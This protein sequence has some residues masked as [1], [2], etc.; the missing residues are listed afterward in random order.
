MNGPL[1]TR[2]GKFKGKLVVK[3]EK[4]QE[5]LINEYCDTSWKAINDEFFTRRQKSEAIAEFIHDMS[6]HLEEAK[7][8]KEMQDM[9][10]MDARFIILYKRE[11]LLG[12]RPEIAVY[13][14]S[15]G[16]NS[17][18]AALKGQDRHMS[19][20]MV[21]PHP[22]RYHLLSICVLFVCLSV[23]VLESIFVVSHTLSATSSLSLSLSPLYPC[24]TSAHIPYQ[25]T[26]TLILAGSRRRWGRDNCETRSCQD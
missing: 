17:M 21:R 14:Q 2:G 19:L 5:R 22:T 18:T 7:N 8:Q 23:C 12:T 20:G 16:W 26:C 15:V 10:R 3:T 4:G 1:S 11:R 6:I 24:F 9:Q 13:V 25:L